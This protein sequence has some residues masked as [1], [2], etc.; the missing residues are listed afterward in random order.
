MAARA[1]RARPRGRGEAGFTLLELLITLAVM[2]IGMTGILGLQLATTR[3]NQ[4]A[5]QTAEGVTIAQRTLEEARSKTLAQLLADHDDD[6]AL[7]I[8]HDFD[9]Q[10]VTGRT[11]TYL[12][13]ITVEATEASDDLLRVRVEVTWADDGAAIGDPDHTHVVSVE[14]LRTRQEAF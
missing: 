9:A 13:R 14:L 12:R 4:G 2:V 7:P 6:G 1:R 10:T 8:D 3:A 11:T 5:S